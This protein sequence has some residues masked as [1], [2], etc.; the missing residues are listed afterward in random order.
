[1]NSQA[2][3]WSRERCCGMILQPLLSPAGDGGLGAAGEACARSQG[4]ET[5]L[6]TAPGPRW[7]DGL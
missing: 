6:E 7:D 3:V 1:M 5:L 2:Q 4:W